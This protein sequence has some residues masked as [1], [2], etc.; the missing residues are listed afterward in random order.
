MTPTL[1]FC[2]LL[3]LILPAAFAQP[4][5]VRASLSP[6]TIVEGKT[7]TLEI[8]VNGRSIQTQPRLAY[9]GLTINA[10]GISQQII[11]G[12]RSSSLRYQVSAAKVG[13]Y[14]IQVPPIQVDA[15]TRAGVNRVTLQVISAASVP[16]NQYGAMTTET[17]FMVFS[18]SAT[19]LYRRQVT[20]AT[21]SVYVRDGAVRNISASIPQNLASETTLRELPARREV[22]SGATWTVYSY[23][24]RMWPIAPGTFDVQPEV[25]VVIS[26]ASG[27]FGFSMARGSQKKLQ[28]VKPVRVRVNDFPEDRR[29]ASFTEAV[30]NFSFTAT[31]SPNSIQLGDPITLRMTIATT[32]SIIQPVQA[33]L[34]PA[35][36]DF[37][38]YPPKLVEESGSEDRLG[39]NKV[40]EQVIE[41]IR[42]T[43]TE[44]PP[45]EFSYFD[46][47]KRR[48]LQV[49][50]GPFPITVAPAAD[51]S[52]KSNV[53]I[54]RN[55]PPADQLLYPIRKASAWRLVGSAAWYKSPLVIGAQTLPLAAIIACFLLAHRRND[56]ATDVAKARRA[57]A[58]KAAREGLAAA[59]HAVETKDSHAF[60]EG[61]WQALTDYFG[62]RLN[63]APGEVEATRVQAAFPEQ[64]DTIRDL[65]SACEAQRYGGSAT[66]KDLA[67]RLQ[68][69]QELVQTCE[70]TEAQP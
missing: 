21:M 36:D 7:S 48:Y 17:E 49:S 44:L 27:G 22:I 68:T 23:R 4:V 54:M 53:N 2:T 61:V 31:A 9:P 46:P 28:A 58:P 25:T 59:E 6:S 60:H 52:H 29:P 14:S 19:N 12:A 11:N 47:I 70:K 10:A 16:K 40:Y 1:R 37:K 57:Q 34:F 26:R 33:P 39:G 38:V 20:D 55:T 8:K 15:N 66:A 42:D 43:L 64:A 30:G 51:G 69:L 5:S 62:N 56:L 65:F 24:V 32:D 3:L 67:A 13:T 63:L 50:R 18:M 41:P 45:V 35:G